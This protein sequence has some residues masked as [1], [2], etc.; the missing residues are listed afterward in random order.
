MNPSST[1][2]IQSVT[3]IPSKRQQHKPT[4]HTEGKCIVTIFFLGYFGIL[5]PILAIVFSV[6]F[7][8]CV[9]VA[10]PGFSML[11]GR[12]SALYTSPAE[13]ESFFPIFFGGG[14]DPQTGLPSGKHTQNYGKSQFLIGN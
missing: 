3:D 11:G 14:V 1:V 9:D 2:R 10:P 5:T 7:P 8:I 12:A 6:Y 13:V 4:N